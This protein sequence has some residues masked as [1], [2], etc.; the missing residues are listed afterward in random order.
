[1]RSTDRLHRG[2]IIDAA[3]KKVRFYKVLTKN[4]W[5]CH[6]GNYKYDLPKNGKPGA[7]STPIP[8]GNLTRCVNGYHVADAVSLFGSWYTPGRHVYLVEVRAALLVDLFRDDKIVCSSIRL[9]KRAT[10]ARAVRLWRKLN[11]DCT[12]DCLEFV[13]RDD[14][15]LDKLLAGSAK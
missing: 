12:D 3:I 6:G 8:V 7:W 2:N 13:V 9:I 1:M 14:R 11:D 15:R 10:V 5:A 4:G